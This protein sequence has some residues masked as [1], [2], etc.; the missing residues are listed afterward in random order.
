MTTLL[1]R[2]LEPLKDKL[3]PEME[4]LIQDEVAKIMPQLE[5]MLQ[6]EMNRVVPLIEAAVAAEV[7]KGIESLIQKLVKDTP[8]PVV[9]V[10]PAPQ[11]A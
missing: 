10:E 6:D 3:L 5:Q 1:D 2:I 4:K 8:A 11:I 9:P 7:D